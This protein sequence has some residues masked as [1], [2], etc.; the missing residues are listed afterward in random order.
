V[1][2]ELSHVREMVRDRLRGGN[3]PTGE[4]ND[5]LTLLDALE[6]VLHNLNIARPAPQ[7]RVFPRDE[8]PFSRRSDPQPHAMALDDSRQVERLARIGSRRQNT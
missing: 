2:R 3:V 8:R 6:S 5:Y 4:W 7:F 1:Q